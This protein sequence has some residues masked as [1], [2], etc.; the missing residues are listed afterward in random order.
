MSRYIVF[1]DIQDNQ[2]ALERFLDKIDSYHRDAVVYL[3][4]KVAPNYPITRILNQIPDLESLEETRDPETGRLGGS[5]LEGGII[6][7][8]T[9]FSGDGKPLTDL[10][11]MIKELAF[12]EKFQGHD[13]FLFGGTNKRG[14]YGFDDCSNDIECLIENPIILDDFSKYFIN[15]GSLGNPPGEQGFIILDTA[16]REAAFK[17]I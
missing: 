16:R 10:N 5:I 12:M 4:D 14:V 1:S 15:P 3:G 7:T 9:S 8:Y 2:E 6:A 13:I 17:E 11:S